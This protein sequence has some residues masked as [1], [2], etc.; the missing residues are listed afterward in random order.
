MT[1]S[2][3]ISWVIPCFNEEEVIDQCINKIKSV[4]SKIKEYSF[5]LILIDDGSTDKTR[6]IIKQKAKNDPLKDHFFAKGKK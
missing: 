4:S 2:N 6:S 5:E 3:L 1:T